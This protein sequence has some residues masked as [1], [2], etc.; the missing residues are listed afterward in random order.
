MARIRSLKPEF[1]SD[2]DVADL[3]PLLRLLFAGMWCHCDREGRLKDKPRTIKALALPFDD[4]DINAALQQLHDAGFII[5]YSA[6]GVG[7]IQVR[8]WEKHQRP[9][10]VKLR[11]Q[12]N[13]ASLLLKT[14]V[15]V[16]N[17]HSN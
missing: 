9:H 1:F 3:P 2:E 8:T 10:Q 16:I 11:S 13:Q 4:I 12:F 17:I 14:Q 6:E 7:Y 5:R 15:H